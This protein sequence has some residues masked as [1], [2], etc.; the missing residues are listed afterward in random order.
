MNKNTGKS[1]SRRTH[2]LSNCEK[3][4]PDPHSQ[5]RRGSQ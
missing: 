1:K 5:L 2:V 3:K 4:N